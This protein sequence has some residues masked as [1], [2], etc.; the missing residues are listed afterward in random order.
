MLSPVQNKNEVLLLLKANS[1]KIKSYGVDS[2][3]LFGSFVK[4]TAT[5]SSD[6]DLLVSFDPNKK[7]FDNFMELSFFLEDLFG[8]KVE[9]VTPQS[10]SKYIGPHI[11]QQAEHVAI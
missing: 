6:V 5:S 9:L 8:R 10:L 11:L 4:G 3:S 2:L 7:G 1:N